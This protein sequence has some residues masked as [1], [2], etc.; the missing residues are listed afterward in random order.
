MVSAARKSK[1]NL[2]LLFLVLSYLCAPPPLLNLLLKISWIE[3]CLW[4]C[5]PPP[6]S[7]VSLRDMRYRNRRALWGVFCTVGRNSQTASERT[8]SS[9][10]RS[11]CCLVFRRLSFSRGDDSKSHLCHLW[12]LALLDAFPVFCS[13]VFLQR[14]K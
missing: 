11:L 12:L 3:A 9:A 8:Y 6:E 4:I 5:E 7:R 10:G 2:P 1:T 14:V 13:L